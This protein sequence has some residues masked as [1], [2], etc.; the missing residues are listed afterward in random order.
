[1]C[2][3]YRYPYQISLVLSHYV[4]LLY[5]SISLVFLLLPLHGARLCLG[6]FCGVRLFFWLHRL[7]NI[8]KYPFISFH[9]TEA[10]KLH[11]FGLEPS[12]LCILTSRLN[13]YAT[14]ID[15]R[16]C[17]FLVYITDAGAGAD[18]RRLR[19]QQ[20]EPVPLLRR[21]RSRRRQQREPAVAASGGGE[22]KT[23]WLTLVLSRTCKRG[24]DQAAA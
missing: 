24:S 5:R 8:L 3:Q 16:H 20:R 13:H 18:T 19:R 9:P 10:K 2:I 7:T 1:M 14:I 4:I 11:T 6:F 12:L 21:A 23:Q 22:I 17:F 15:I